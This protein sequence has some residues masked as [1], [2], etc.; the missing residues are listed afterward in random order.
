MSITFV[1][2]GVPIAFRFA[3]PRNNAGRNLDQHGS[4]FLPSIKTAEA[5]KLFPQGWTEVR[6]YLRL[7]TI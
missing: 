6:P 1:Q 3:N 5:E 7:T 4:I 2:R